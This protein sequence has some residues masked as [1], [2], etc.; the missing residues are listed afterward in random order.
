MT[1]TRIGVS[2]LEAGWVLGKT[3]SQIRRLLRDGALTYLVAPRWITPES[4]R[5]L[6]GDE[7]DL[8]TEALGAILTGDIVAPRPSRRYGPA[9]PIF[10]HLLPHL[11]S[12]AVLIHHS[13]GG[14]CDACP[15][16]GLLFGEVYDS[17]W[18]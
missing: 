6:F 1:T 4:I 13:C 9:Q 7:D 2:V 8:G 15:Q 12:N 14:S 10:P 3:E 11:L 17:P 18:P 16:V 5:A